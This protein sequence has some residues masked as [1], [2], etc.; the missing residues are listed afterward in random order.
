M[1]RHRGLAYLR[2]TRPATP[3]LYSR[4]EEFP[5]G[6]SKVVAKGEGDA[7]TVIAAGITVFE[8]LKAAGELKTEGLGLRVIDAYSVEPIDAEGIRR[9]VRETGGRAIV[10]EDHFPGGGLGEAVASA[11]AGGARLV[12]LCVRVLPRSGKAGELMDAAGI[13]APHIVRAARELVRG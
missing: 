4:D 6:G 2:T 5:L 1:T 7:V 3:I 9:E 12:H 11:L 10:V 8:A 13:S